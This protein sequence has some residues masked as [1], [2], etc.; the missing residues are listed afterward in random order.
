M[1][2]AGAVR[3]LRQR[4]M[5][6]CSPEVLPSEQIG[7]ATSASQ[8]PSPMEVADRQPQSHE[9]FGVPVVR[10]CCSARMFVTLSR[11]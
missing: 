1:Y 6:Q 4:L 10:P 9:R 2:W 7:I 11:K 8:P 3:L 5:S